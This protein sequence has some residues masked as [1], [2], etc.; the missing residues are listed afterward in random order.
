VV[1]RI[2]VVVPQELREPVVSGVEHLL[3][4]RVGRVGHLVGDADHFVLGPEQFAE[5]GL[6]LVEQ[7]AAGGKLLVLLQEH[8]LG[9][10]VQADVTPVRRVV[11]GE[12]AHERGLAGP[13]RTDEADPLAV[14]Q[15]EGQVV[16]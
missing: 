10:G 6:G 7:G 4:G 11:T 5:S 8:H 15:L 3:L 12:D 14:V 1:E 2:R 13:V 16:E 9:P